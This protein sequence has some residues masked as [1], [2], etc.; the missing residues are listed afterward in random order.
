GR[1]PLPLRPRRFL[2]RRRRL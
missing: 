2:G 1:V